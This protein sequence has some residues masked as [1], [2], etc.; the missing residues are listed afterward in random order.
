MNVTNSATLAAI[1]LADVVARVESSGNP[2]AVRYESLH[3]PLAPYIARMVRVAVCSY[4]TAQV[5]CQSSW[6]LYQIMGDELMAL[7]L[8]QSPVQYCSDPGIQRFMFQK[9]L[10]VNGLL[11]AD[12]PPADFF[13][14]EHEADVLDFARRYNGPGQPAVYAANLRNAFARLSG[15]A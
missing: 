8:G 6:G 14:P 7:G 5:L 4:A 11:Y 2:W 12:I 1:S 9:Y 3:R 13:A 15:G 10:T